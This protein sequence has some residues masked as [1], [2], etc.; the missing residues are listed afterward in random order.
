MKVFALAVGLV[1]SSGASARDFLVTDQ[2]QATILDMCQV[3]ARAANLPLEVNVQFGQWCLT[4][5]RRIQ[6]SKVEVPDAQQ[7]PQAGAADGRGGPQPGVRQEGGRA[8]A[9]R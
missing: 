9:G 6:A 5:N 1:L 7:V 2:D 4:W 3:A 8:P